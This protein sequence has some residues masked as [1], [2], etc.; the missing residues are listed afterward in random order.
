VYHLASWSIVVTPGEAMRRI[1]V[2]PT[3]YASDQPNHTVEFCQGTCVFNTGPTVTL[4]FS[5][6]G[7]YRLSLYWHTLDPT[8]LI[9][10]PST[11]MEW[12][13]P[14]ETTYRI[15]CPICGPL[16]IGAT[17]VEAA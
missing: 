9:N 3:T 6:E 8:P 13:T 7:A 2:P 14:L 11:V 12:G 5:N 16:V 10:P 15:P 17:S 1:G 4:I